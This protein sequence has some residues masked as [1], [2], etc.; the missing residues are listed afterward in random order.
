MKLQIIIIFISL[1]A[2]SSCNK[3]EAI[4][5]DPGKDANKIYNIELIDSKLLDIAEPSGLSWALNQTDFIIVDDR[6]NKAFVVD[7]EGNKISEF[8]YSGDD[9]EGVTINRDSNEIWIAEE[10]ESE[11][12]RLNVNGVKQE[13]YKIDISRGSDKKGLEGLTYDFSNKIFYI[14]NEG[15]PGLLIKW[16]IDSGIISEK[17]LDFAQDYSGIF[18]DNADQSLWIVSDQSKKL[19]F[20]DKDA[21]VKQ[22]FDLDYKKAEGVVVDIAHQRVYIISDYE[23][24]LYIYK[25]TKL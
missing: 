22:S 12:I 6:T 11:L 25:I 2:F 10:A 15:E 5:S 18:F 8:P 20:C 4:P 16:K 21:K 23:H 7:K 9:T 3:D 17:Q 1:L 13:S 19:F 14:L 24:K